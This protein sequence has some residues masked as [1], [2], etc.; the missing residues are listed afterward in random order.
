MSHDKP[1]KR[2]SA[3]N[4]PGGAK[5]RTRPADVTIFAAFDEPDDEED[6]ICLAGADASASVLSFCHH[7]SKL[8]KS[9]YPDRPPLPAT[10]LSLSKR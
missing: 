8:Y 4:T 7:L 6:R 9:L 2:K 5:K 3:P 10:A 1:R